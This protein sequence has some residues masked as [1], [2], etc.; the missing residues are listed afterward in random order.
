M[1]AVAPQA[2]CLAVVGHTIVRLPHERAACAC[3]AVFLG[4][5]GVEEG[6]F[7]EGLG[8]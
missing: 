6:R 5:P 7:A 8:M 4:S 2:G 1:R 3:A